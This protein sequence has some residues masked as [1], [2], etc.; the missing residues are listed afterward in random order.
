MI[1]E[2]SFGCSLS[3]PS[4]SSY[5][6]DFFSSE[7]DCTSSSSSSSLTQLGSHK[8]T[9]GRKKF[10]ET[11]HPI[12]R[13]VRARKNDKWVC[14]VREPNSKSRIWLGTH[15]SAEI[16]ARAYDVAAIALRG[17]SAPL[18]FEDSLWLLPRA[19]S[20]SA[21]DIQLAASEAV[22]AFPFPNSK[23]PSSVA[24]KS[25]KSVKSTKQTVEIAE[26]VSATFFDEEALYYMPALIASM[27]EGMLLDPPQ[28]GYY[29]DD[30]VESNVESSLWSDY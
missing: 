12:Y 17:K 14:E 13:G 23:K 27:A 9:S 15:S 19:K 16:A 4:S 3:S 26:E 24:K 29:Y 28:E 10:K 5:S 30:D 21:K 25:S 18:N 6:T 1:F 20:S 8:K 2:D 7:T 22:R 11:R